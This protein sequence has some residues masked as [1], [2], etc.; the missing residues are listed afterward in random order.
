MM[1]R[2]KEKTGI[3]VIGK[4]LRHYFATERWKSG[5][6]IEMFSWALGHQNLDVTRRYMDMDQE[7]LAEATENLFQSNEMLQRLQENCYKI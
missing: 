4:K 1:R 2:P 6:W 3:T 7:V 5:W